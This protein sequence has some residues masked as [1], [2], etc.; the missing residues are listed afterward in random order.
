MQTCRDCSRTSRVW[1]RRQPAP[2]WDASS[3]RSPKGKE[4][5]GG[6]PVRASWPRCV[7]CSSKRNTEGKLAQLLLCGTGPGGHR[8]G[9]VYLEA[10]LRDHHSRSEPTSHALGGEPSPSRLPCR[11]QSSE[12]RFSP[13]GGCTWVAPCGTPVAFKM[14]SCAAVVSLGQAP[15]AC[16]ASLR[17]VSPARPFSLGGPELL[18]RH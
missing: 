7:Q 10:A 1:R 13:E 12:G 15:S 11:A 2:P 16:Q 14:G 5:W 6:L 17:F 8:K 18:P 9:K 4:D 3:I